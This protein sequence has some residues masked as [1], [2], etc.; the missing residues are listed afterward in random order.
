MIRLVIPVLTTSK[1]ATCG[2]FDLN[3]WRAFLTVF[4]NLSFCDGASTREGV[5]KPYFRC[6][7]AFLPKQ[8]DD[9]TTKSPEWGSRSR[10]KRYAGLGKVAGR[11]IKP[12]PLPAMQ[13]QLPLCIDI[14]YDKLLFEV[15]SKNHF[16]SN[17]FK[18]IAYYRT[19]K[20]LTII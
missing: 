5:L 13:N 18:N 11:L 7:R 3:F 17:F 14:L 1:F 16:F 20:A 4:G 12:A 6:E 10:R 8:A 2:N 15:N 19:C 9:A